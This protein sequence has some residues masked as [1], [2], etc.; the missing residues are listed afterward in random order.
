MNF[1]EFIVIIVVIIAV[2]LLGFM[3]IVGK[4]NLLE[5]KK[6]GSNKNGTNKK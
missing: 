1:L 4:Y 3:L 5:D 6:E 2:F